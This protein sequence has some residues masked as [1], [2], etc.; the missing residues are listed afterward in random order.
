MT[1]LSLSAV[2]NEVL[3]RMNRWVLDKP[4]EEIKALEN[5]HKRF[6]LYYYIALNFFA[7]RDRIKLPDC[8]IAAVRHRYPQHIDEDDYVGH[9]D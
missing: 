5:R 7:A 3:I 8:V 6:I 2:S 9:K 4:P 1:G